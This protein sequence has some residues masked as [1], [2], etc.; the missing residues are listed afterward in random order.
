MSC[1]P[2]KPRELANRC[3]LCHEDVGP[4]EIGWKRHLITEGCPNSQR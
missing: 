2:G 4:F 3:P 1:I